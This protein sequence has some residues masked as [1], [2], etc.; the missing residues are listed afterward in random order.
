MN[1]SIL[2]TGA[3]SGIGYAATHA[4]AAAGY[5]VFATHRSDSQRPALAS[6][7]GVH[8][9]RMDVTDP[10][11]RDQAYEQVRAAVGADGLYA[12]LNIAGL[13]HSAPFEY[14]DDKKARE[15]ME[16]NVMAPYLVTKRLLPL[17]TDYNRTHA[18]HSRVMNI[19]SWAGLMASPF[20][21]FYNASEFAVIGLTE[22]MYYDLGL[23]GI[24]TILGIPGLTKTPLLAKTTDDAT[25]SLKAMPDDGQARYRELFDHYATMSASSADMPMLATPESVARKLVRIVDRRN[26]RFK[27]RLGMDAVVI[28]SIMTKLPWQARVVMNNRMYQL[29]RG[30]SAV[31]T[32]TPAVAA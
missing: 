27:Y 9:V 23:L 6:I 30:L 32:R 7:P 12:L 29:N 8:P 5:Q 17:L 20:I 25:A 2:I 3:A 14:T 16:V 28:D 13:T 10:D 18:I 26:P 11:D 19:A 1:K 4:F 24:H 15:V 31:P 21:P 22:S